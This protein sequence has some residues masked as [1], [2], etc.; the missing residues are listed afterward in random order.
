MVAY[1][2]HWKMEMGAFFTNSLLVKCSCFDVLLG[3]VCAPHLYTWALNLL[4][5]SHKILCPRWTGKERH[6]ASV[7][8]THCFGDWNKQKSSVL[9]RERERGRGKY[10]ILLAL[11]TKPRILCL[12]SF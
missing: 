2:G 3:C 4:H 6:L 12:D 9:E 10:L 5:L 8:Q 1:A 11:P 7:A